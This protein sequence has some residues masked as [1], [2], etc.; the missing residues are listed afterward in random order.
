MAFGKSAIALGA[1]ALLGIFGASPASAGTPH[2]GVFTE[3]TGSVSIVTEGLEFSTSKLMNERRF[4]GVG[5]QF[6]CWVEIGTSPEL[7]GSQTYSYRFTEPSGKSV[8]I[9]PFAIQ[10]GGFGSGKIP[11]YYT[12]TWRMEFFLVGRDNGAKAPIGA[13]SFTITP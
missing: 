6:G 10:A 13:T 8:E 4:S 2:C 3:D 1:T 9:G 11:A 5:P 7:R 12:G